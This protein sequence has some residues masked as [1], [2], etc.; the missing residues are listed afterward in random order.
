LTDFESSPSLNSVQ[1][2]SDAEK[3]TLIIIR[4]ERPEDIATIRLV[5]LEAFGQP[6][7]ANLI[8]MLRTN[9]GILLSLVATYHSQVIGHILYSPVTA[10]FSENKIGG[11]GLGPMAVLPEYQ[12]QGVGGKLIEFGIT[13]LKQSG[14][15]FIVVL[16]HVDYY[17]RFGF[18][19]ASDYGL[20]CEWSVPD[21]AFMAL[22]L[23]ESK[24]GGLSGLAKYRA[25][26]SSVV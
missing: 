3:I 1:G 18:R 4:E 12:R 22:V 19:S 21:N 23:D 14:C 7:E 17:A 8:E 6:Q 15:P 2:R 20:K 26:F 16:G 11:A 5:N 24:I 10:G 9:G 13:R 25:E